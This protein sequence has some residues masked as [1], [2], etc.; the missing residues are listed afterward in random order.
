MFI[1]I[2]LTKLLC[3]LYRN[4]LEKKQFILKYAV[5]LFLE[6]LQTVKCNYI[7]INATTT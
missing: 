1:F 7:T 6:F 2:N 3:F 5:Y 4:S